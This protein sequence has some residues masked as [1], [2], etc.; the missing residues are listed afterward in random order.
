MLSKIT[1]TNIIIVLFYCIYYYLFK[2]IIIIPKNDTDCSWFIVLTL[3]FESFD[4]K[5]I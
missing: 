2:Y 4:K 1:K 3:S 5:L